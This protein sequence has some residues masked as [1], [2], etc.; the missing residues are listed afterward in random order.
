MYTHRSNV[1]HSYASCLPDALNITGRDAI[2]P[3]VPMFHAN[4]WG[5]AYSAVLAGAKLVMP[6]AGMDGRSVWD[7]LDSERVTYAAGVPTVWMLLLQYC[8][9]HGQWHRVE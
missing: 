3:V 2:M 1:L 5:L 7:L 6:G 4:S 8:E 9:Q